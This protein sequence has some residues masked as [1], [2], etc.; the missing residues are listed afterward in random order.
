MAPILLHSPVHPRDDVRWHFTIPPAP[1]SR[2]GKGPPRTGKQV[3]FTEDGKILF[4]YVQFPSNRILHNDDP[5]QF[6][7]ASFGAFSFR[8]TYPDE[9]RSSVSAYMKRFFTAGLFLN[10]VQYRFY[11]HS[12]SQLRSRGC[13]LRAARS[14]SE[15]DKR[16]YA[17]GDFE[18]IKNIAKR[19]FLP[20]PRENTC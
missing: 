13:F 4:D 2:P 16:I 3:S 9:P 18:N 1:R 5:S 19:T 11:G 7:L 17:L 6:V 10:G 12:N 8:I 20:F 14:D 15:L